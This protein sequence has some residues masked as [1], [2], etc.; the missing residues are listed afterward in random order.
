MADQAP[1][2][3]PYEKLSREELE[4]HSKRNIRYIKTLRN[5]NSELIDR[6]KEAESRLEEQQKIN[7]ELQAEIEKLQESQKFSQISFGNISKKV[8]QV[9][10]KIP[11]QQHGGSVELKFAKFEDVSI[12]PIEN[13]DE[14]ESPKVISLQA[15]VSQLKQSLQTAQNNEKAIKEFAASL[16]TKL[17]SK[18]IKIEELNDLKLQLNDSNRFLEESNNENESLKQKIARLQNELSNEQSK[19]NEIQQKLPG[20]QHAS[21]DL[22][23]LMTKYSDLVEQ[24]ESMKHETIKQRVKQEELERQNDQLKESLKNSI[25]EEQE[26]DEQMRQSIQKNKEIE[27]EKIDIQ[28][29]IDGLKKLVEVKDNEIESIKKENLL[30]QERLNSGKSSLETETRIQKMQRMVEKSN[31]LYVEMQ[32]RANKS[33]ERVRELEKQIYTQKK[34]GEPLFQV[35]TPNG[36]FLLYDSGSYMKINDGQIIKNIKHYHLNAQDNQVKIDI[37]VTADLINDPYQEDESK[38]EYLQNLLRQFFK[39][40]QKIKNELTPIILNLIGLNENEVKHT[41]N[42][43]PTK[44][45]LSLFE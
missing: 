21:Q 43:S 25:R 29:Q 32:Q 40:N 33:E 8:T 26:K 19:R 9:L 38:Y 44:R 20:L 12:E 6:I 42:M 5:Q 15:Q 45:I 1:S 14:N 22:Q 3:N 7:S 28:R 31:T 13:S 4:E 10:E 18:E 2:Q 23:Q 24:F 27:S 11:F 34:K 35:S 30:I 36:L 17:E 37:S 16:Q 41:M 39:S